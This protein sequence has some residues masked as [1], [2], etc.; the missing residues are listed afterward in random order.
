MPIDT[1]HTS[2]FPSA[3]QIQ[4]AVAQLK[5]GKTPGPNQITPSILKA[6]GAVFAKQFALLTAKAASQASEPFAWRGGR[7]APLH[8]GKGPPDEP[9]SYRSIF[10]SNYTGKIYHRAIRAQLEQ[11]WEA[12]INALQL[13]SRKGLGTDLA[14]HLLEAHQAACHAQRIPTAI[15]FF[16]MRSAFYSVLRQSLVHLPQDPTARIHALKRMGVSQQDIEQ[17]IAAT[18]EDNATDGASLHLQH[19]VRDTMS[20]TFF[21]VSHLTQLCCTTRGTRPGDPLGDLLFNMIMRLIMQDCKEWFI[22]HTGCQ[23]LGDTKHTSSFAEAPDMPSSAFLDLAYVDDAAIALHAQSLDELVTLIQHA[24][25]AMHQATHKRGM[26]LNFEKGKTEVLWN[27]AGKGSTRVKLQIAQQGGFLC[28]SGLEQEFRLSVTQSYKHLGTWLQA[29]PRC[30]R[31]VYNRASLAKSAW[32]SLARTLYS[33]SYVSMETKGKAFQALTMSRLLYNVHT[34][35]SAQDADWIKW[36]N[37]MRKP[38]G[39]LVKHLLLG[40][41]PTHVDTVDLFG[42]ADIL[43][44]CDQAHIARLRYVKRLI[45][46]CPQALWMCLMAAKEAPTSW[47]AACSASFAWFRQFYHK[48]FGPEQSD[49]FFDWL[50]FVAMDT[51]WKG[52]LRAAARAC[53]RH[54]RAEAEHNLWQK[55]F[56]RNFVAGGGILPVDQTRPTETWACDTCSKTFASRKALATHAGRVHGYRRLVNFLPW[57]MFAMLV[58]SCTIPDRG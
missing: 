43:S 5:R 40:T 12:K 3:W 47:I 45:Q 23:W 14:H 25:M 31:D 32:G 38:L 41:P 21:Q 58:E 37:H 1:Q 27:V 9:Q 15:V 53:K 22:Q 55:K 36:Q 10:I 33:K 6:A 48:S 39:L 4:A 46:Y 8:K 49:S 42:I 57:M 11:V 24:A 16:D 35:C 56:D 2:C 18:H 17:W 50:P 44:P 34:W 26:M 51:R 7:L 52:R 28:W 20:Q 29:P 19:L 13:G 54:R 30:A